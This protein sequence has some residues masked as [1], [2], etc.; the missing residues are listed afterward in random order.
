[1]AAFVASTRFTVPLN[2]NVADQLTV[3][4][5]GSVVVSAASSGAV[6]GAGANVLSIDGDI[7]NA[8]V[9]GAGLLL[10]AGADNVV[11]GATG[12]IHGRDDG[13][14][15]NGAGS[16]TF[17]S[18]GQVTGQTGNAVDMTGGGNTFTLNATSIIRGQTD[19]ILVSGGGNSFANTGVVSG[20]S[21]S[22]V[23]FGAGSNTIFNGGTILGSTDGILIDAGGLNTIVNTGIIRSTFGNAIAS[24]SSINLTNS[25]TIDCVAGDGV[26]V[27]SG[28][29]GCAIVN[30]G[31]IIGHGGVALGLSSS[32]ASGDTVVNNG[33][34]QGNQT[35]A[36]LN[37]GNDFFDG[38][39]GLQFG[40]VDGG[41]GDDTLFGGA[42]ADD[43]FGGADNDQL[44]GGAGPDRLDGGN[45]FDFV[46]YDL[47]GAVTV[48]LANAAANTGDAAGDT[49][50]F[51]E[52]V[53]GSNFNDTIVGDGSA[54]TLLGLG[55][56]DV[57]FGEAGGDLI[58]GGVGGDVIRG[59]LGGDL[60]Q[61][62]LGD[63]GDL[64]QAFNEAGV[65]DGF[66]LRGY[67]DATG[68]TGTDPR[69]AGVMQ[70][71][72][73]G[74]DTD[75][76]LHGAFAFRIEGVVAAAIDDSYF[77]FQ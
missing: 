5:E 27:F 76:H 22:A 19:A 70:V 43:L 26:D 38:R 2:L 58:T 67:F 64:I 39:N 71:L 29:E 63:N 17:T 13:V 32:A 74:A 41:S 37:A 15:I 31:F 9:T 54:N 57:L 40:T 44:L 23:F 18:N 53:I 46:R 42:G 11:V 60:F 55:G 68:F 56:A 1:M 65:R 35:A 59:G 28:A 62:N 45:D 30:N 10:N 50:F 47:G 20:D 48:S 66:D 61:F 14:R 25:G 77:L 24:A 7:A 8:N 51:I 6:V 52:G 21:A 34:L 36:F 69:G 73:N 33:F 75:V 49:F 3:T 16:N 72:Q 4:R 12:S